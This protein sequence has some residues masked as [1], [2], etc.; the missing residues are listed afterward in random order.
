MQS[1]RTRAARRSRSALSADEHTAGGRGD[2]ATVCHDVRVQG[3]HSRATQRDQCGSVG[4]AEQPNATAT[5]AAAAADDELW[6]N[7]LI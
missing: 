1:E 7:Q 5:T 3:A 4:A 6:V 2:Q